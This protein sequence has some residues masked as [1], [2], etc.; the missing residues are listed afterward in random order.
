MPPVSSA[1]DRLS[2]VVI[3]HADSSSLP[4][5]LSHRDLLLAEQDSQQ[6]MRGLRRKSVRSPSLASSAMA[7]P[8]AINSATAPS[9][10]CSGR[11]LAG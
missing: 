10:F 4:L 3:E 6:A 1:F 9:I 8:T 7:R 5:T 11:W 2:L